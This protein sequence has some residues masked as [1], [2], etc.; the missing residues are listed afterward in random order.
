VTAAVADQAAEQ[1]AVRTCVRCGRT[2]QRQF[3]ATAS[4]EW[5]CTRVDACERRRSL[6]DQPAAEPAA[7]EQPASN[8]DVA[9]SHVDASLEEG[10][11]PDGDALTLALI[12]IALD[13]VTAVHA[14]DRAAV[15][16]LLDQAAL[17]SSDPLTGARHLAIIAAGMCSEDHAAPASLG[18]TV[19]PAA[20]HQLRSGTDALTASLR[21]GR[22]PR[23][24][25]CPTFGSTTSST[26][27]SS[28][29]E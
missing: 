3:A 4:G 25:T 12:P 27:E 29:A 28:G 18:W 23:E 1:L 20:Y 22:T 5:L 13:L 11:E 24:D 6:R 9:A 15:A 2:G 16:A 7:V 19:N 21:A 14:L 10:G 26:P 17:L 8:M